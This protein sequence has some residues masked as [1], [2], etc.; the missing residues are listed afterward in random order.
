MR[1]GDYRT[2]YDPSRI[3]NGRRNLLLFADITDDDLRW[4]RLL[5]LQTILV[6][7]QIEASNFVH[8]LV[9]L[10]QQSHNVL[11]KKTAGTSDEHHISGRRCCGR[12]EVGHLLSKAQL[13]EPEEDLKRLRAAIERTHSNFSFRFSADFLSH[14]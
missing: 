14:C 9:V 11:A 3:F 8:V 2:V 1:I 5:V 13:S 4:L 10:L 12:I 6:G 7:D